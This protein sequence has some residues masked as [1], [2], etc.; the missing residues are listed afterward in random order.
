MSS[1]FLLDVRML[2]LQARL[3]EILNVSIDQKTL[4]SISFKTC[5]RAFETPSRAFETLDQIFEGLRE[6]QKLGRE[7]EK[8]G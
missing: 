7:F 1:R 4:L 3:S 5:G 6:K 2:F 8:L